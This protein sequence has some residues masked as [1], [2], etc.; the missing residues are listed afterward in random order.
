MVGT[1]ALTTPM[2]HRGQSAG[3]SVL[4]SRASKDPSALPVNSVKSGRH[5][6]VITFATPLHVLE[7][8]TMPRF[9][10]EDTS[11]IH[12]CLFMYRFQKGTY[13]LQQ[14]HIS[15]I[16]FFIVFKLSQQFKK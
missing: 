4:A 13:I 2:G 12:R 8:M 16:T 6:N 10:G 15:I 11:H 1:V 14:L 9:M 3:I 5:L 7:L